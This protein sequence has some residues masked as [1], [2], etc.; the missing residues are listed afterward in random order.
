MWIQCSTMEWKVLLIGPCVVP[1]AHTRR[2]AHG[3]NYGG[4]VILGCHIELSTVEYIVQIIVTLKFNFPSEI[5]NRKLIK[6]KPDFSNNLLFQYY[7]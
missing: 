6:V 3:K 5:N 1:K 4:G 2:W 7:H